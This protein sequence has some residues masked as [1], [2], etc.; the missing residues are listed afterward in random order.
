MEWFSFS[1]T[2]TTHEKN[3]EWHGLGR[4]LF[5]DL[6]PVVITFMMAQETEET[7]TEVFLSLARGSI[8]FPGRRSHIGTLLHGSC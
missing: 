2:N 5:L 4:I 7:E 8:S 6:L 1:A 3:V